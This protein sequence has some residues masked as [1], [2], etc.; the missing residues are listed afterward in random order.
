M[1]GESLEGR[2]SANASERKAPEGAGPFFRG[3]VGLANRD[4]F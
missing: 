2:S 1:E 3:L 4:F